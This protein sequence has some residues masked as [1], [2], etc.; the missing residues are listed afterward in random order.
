MEK[1]D[2]N[3]HVFLFSDF[4]ATKLLNQGNTFKEFIK[5][6]PRHFELKRDGKEGITI[7]HFDDGKMLVVK[8][9]SFKVMMTIGIKQMNLDMG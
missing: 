1:D 5:D 9:N 6:P 7:I 8:F 3:N 2:R 4:T